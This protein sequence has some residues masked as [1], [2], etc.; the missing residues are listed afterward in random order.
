[1]KFKNQNLFKI[2]AVFIVFFICQNGYSQIPA[3]YYNTA[4]GTG[5]TLKTQLYNIIKGHDTHSY[6]QLYSGYVTT[7]KDNYYEN[8]GTV[9]DMYSE[10]PDG[11]DPYNYTHP[12]NHCGSYSDEGDCF[13][14][15]HLVPQSFFDENSPMVSD[16]HHV[17]PTDG[18]VNGMR[19]N[20][21]FGEVGTAN[22]TSLNGSKRGACSFPGYTG[23]VF[24]PIDEFKGDI[25]RCLLYFATRYEN[26]VATFSGSFLD[27]SSDQVYVDWFVDLLVKWHNQDPVNQRELDRNDACYDYQGN[28]NPF[29]DH[30]EWVCEIWQSSYCTASLDFTSNPVLTAPINTQYTYTI[31]F[32]GENA[33]LTCVSKPDW[34]TFTDGASG[35][36]KLQGTP[37]SNNLGSENSV[38]LKI[39][40]GIT[41]VFQNYTITVTG[42]LVEITSPPVISVVENNL[43]TY[44]ITYT[45]ALTTLT[46][47]IK[48]TW[49]TFTDNDNGTGK[50]T[51]TPTNAEIGEHIVQLSLTDEYTTDIQD[52]TIS[53]YENIVQFTSEPVLTVNAN[54]TY[55]YNITYMGE[56]ASLSCTEYPAWIT[57]VDNHNGTATLTGVPL[58]ENIG[59]N[60]VTLELTGGTTP[61]Y[62]EFD[63]DVLPN[64]YTTIFNK[65]FNDNSLS[66]G[67]WKSYSIVGDAQI[68]NTSSSQNGLNNTYCAYI[69]GLS[70]DNEDWLISPSFNAND[71]SEKIL[72]FWTLALN[73]GDD[74]LVLYSTNYS[75]SGN[76][77]NATWT[78][79]S[80]YILATSS[81]W[82]SSGNVDISSITST[83]AYI[84]IKYISTTSGAKEWKIDDIMIKGIYDPNSISEQANELGLE[85]FPN[86]F[87][88]N[89]KINYT[90]TENSNIK[91]DIYDI[92]GKK[93]NNIFDN[94]QTSGIHSIEWKSDNLTE[95]G[96]YLI[97]IQTE[98]Q[99][100]YRKIIKK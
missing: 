28:R 57:F 21:P 66:S 83:K 79:L 99:N 61:L 27:G 89:L 95:K 62:Q 10:N 1:M 38:S 67:G 46:C 84:G 4:T 16:I 19:G 72:T 7:D 36:A 48:P 47:P 20:L 96:I 45:G 82:T 42:A 90:L 93:I 50:L 31:S 77:N 64:N 68:W 17:V 39:S 43:Y 81:T 55:T 69:N 60:S 73:S 37:H 70:Q 8:D 3:G 40:D 86:P 52:F 13:N 44:N 75:G 56:G 53:V 26:N 25:A 18:K 85:I 100:Y 74:L 9:L 34:L 11:T 2:T 23:T 92:T 54:E 59:L 12:N 65:D 32:T 87:S 76:P 51:G 94:Y 24:E 22:W 91:I 5:Y 80:E 41:D 33:D 35:V 49:L 78:E 6:N 58:T 97:N 14:R 30:P 98:N 29:I 88:N 71:Y 15:E 63:I